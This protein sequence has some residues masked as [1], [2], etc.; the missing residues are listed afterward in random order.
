MNCIEL[1]NINYQL[2]VV[3][4]SGLPIA[5]G[6]KVLSEDSEN[7]TLAEIL[8]TITDKLDMGMTMYE[9][10]EEEGVFPLYMVEMVRIGENAGKL[11]ETFENLS[12]YYLSRAEFQK[13]LRSAISYPLVLLVM[14]F[15]VL[16]LIVFKV[17]PIFHSLLLSLGSEVPEASMAIFRIAGW[18]KN[19][20]LAF[21]IVLGVLLVILLLAFKTKTMPKTKSYLLTSIPVVGKIYKKNVLVKFTRAVSTLISSGYSFEMAAEKALLLVEDDVLR[22]CFD[23]ALQDIQDGADMYESL[24]KINVFP[25]LFFKMF[26]L[27]ERTGTMD[28]MAA[29]FTFTYQKELD[30]LMDRTASMVEPILVT[31]M[32]IVVG[33]V[34][35]VTLLPLIG[36]ISAIG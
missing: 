11:P 30:K 8:S 14:M 3:Y 22:D 13:K 15:A 26:K 12:D 21:G 34:L 33:V 17:L 25:S 1:S 5:D 24:E 32:S 9:A 4:R 36:I 10:F 7:R 31:V 35:L 29:R 19:S 2:S 6:V 27:G 28:Q 18:L 16:G 23:K 20:L